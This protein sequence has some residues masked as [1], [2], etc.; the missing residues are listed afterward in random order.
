MADRNS[1][2]TLPN[3]RL[4][5]KSER[6]HVMTPEIR[7]LIDDMIAATVDWENSRPHELGVALA[8]IQINH[9][10]RAIIVRNDF[11]D[12]QNQRFTAL[13][14]PEVIKYEGEPVLDNEGCLSVHD[15]YGL[16]PR[17]PKIRLRAI[18]QKGQPVKIKAEGFLARV[19]QHEIDHTNGVAF[20]DRVE[21]QDGFFKLNDQGE[22]E[23]LPYEQV[24]ASGIL[25]H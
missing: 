5:I 8:A 15:V 13:I 20:V 3:P 7:R 4:R 24:A 17:Y 11:E 10:L 6:I 22:L 21:G 19:L 12:K 14:N 25:R 9:P 18:N 16:V 23:P 2:I 1:I